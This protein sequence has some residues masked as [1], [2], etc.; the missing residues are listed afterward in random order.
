MKG[1][2]VFVKHSAFIHDE[3]PFKLGVKGTSVKLEDFYRCLQQT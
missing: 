1:T 2:E 3:N